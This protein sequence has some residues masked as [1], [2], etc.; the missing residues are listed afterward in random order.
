MT[1]PEAGEKSERMRLSREVR[2]GE[3][4]AV[5]VALT[6]LA[7]WYVNQQ[8][9][10]IRTEIRALQLRNLEQDAANLE[11]KREI[12]VDLREVRDKLDR[13]IE[14]QQGRRP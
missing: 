11:F 14:S 4:V 1:D 2:I 13:L 9:E 3:L 8:L 6:G 12:R 10:P 7:G 5:V